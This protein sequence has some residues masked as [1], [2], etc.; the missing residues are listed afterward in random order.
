MTKPIGPATAAAHEL[1][2]VAAQAADDKLGLDTLILD[3]RREEM[4]VKTL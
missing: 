1:A 3:Y 2:R 4:H